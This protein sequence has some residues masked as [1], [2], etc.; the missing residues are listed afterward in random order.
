[1]NKFLKKI[2]ILTLACLLNVNSVL[3]CD[4]KSDNLCSKV[5]LES[6]NS[7]FQNKTSE[8]PSCILCK[9]VSKGIDMTGRKSLVLCQNSSFIANA[10]LG[11]IVEG[12]VLIT[13]KR[14]INSM[15]ELNDKEYSDFVKIQ[16]DVRKG[17]KKIYG[18]NCICFE[19]GSGKNNQEVAAS[20]IKHAHFHMVAIDKFED[21]IHEKIITDMKM[22][23]IENQRELKNYADKPYI[24]YTSGDGKQYLS[25]KDKMES[26]YMRKRIADQFNKEY[27]WKDEN[28]R[29]SFKENVLAT[30]E[31]WKK[32]FEENT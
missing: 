25:T 31:K 24:Y 13:C 17:L 1:M 15:G 10:D 18:K 27:N 32:Y 19:H 12:Y 26:Q 5:D 20:S 7:N 28:V 14:H 8:L 4:I 6:M 23:T 9:I 11:S 29:K 30:E 21:T 16:E 22:F 2:S 3:A